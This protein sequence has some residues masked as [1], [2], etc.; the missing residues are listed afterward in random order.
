MMIVISRKAKVTRAYLAL[1]NKIPGPRE[2]LLE[3]RFCAGPRGRAF[4]TASLT[5]ETQT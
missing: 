2:L 3:S 5:S 1:R 4:Y